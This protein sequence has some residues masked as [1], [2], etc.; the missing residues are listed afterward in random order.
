M[1]ELDF[2]DGF[3]S[4]VEPTQGDIASNKLKK[5]PSDAAFLADKEIDTNVAKKSDIYFNTTID[6]IRYCDDDANFQ[7]LVDATKDFTI[8]GEITFEQAILAKGGVG[9]GVDAS[10][11]AVLEI[12]KT[13]ATEVVLSDTGKITRIKGDLI[14]EG[15]STTVNTVDLDVEDQNI[16]INKGG[17]DAS[18]QG[19]GLTV[20]RT[21]T[22]GNLLFDSTLAS[23]WKAGLDGSEVEL[24][25]VSSAQTLTNKTIDADSNTITNI[26]N[27]DIKSGAAIDRSKLANGTIDHVLINSGAGVMT[28][29]A[30]LAVARGG[31]SHGSYTTGDLLVAT[32][33][34]V[35]SKLGI[36]TNGHVLTVNSGLPSWQPA[37]GGGGGSDFSKLMTSSTD[38]HILVSSIDGLV[39]EFT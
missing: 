34:G 35:L 37:S 24:A 12:G 8:D 29:E 7:T 23:K 25:N 32:A 1:R 22:D 16:T 6:C 33:S 30:Q 14:V 13:N 4:A 11:A 18:A 3:T 10:T 2:T 28:S 15:D 27:A 21:T 20:E 36:G 38:G 39:Y 31:T 5:Y 19:A 26:E 9:G 17:N